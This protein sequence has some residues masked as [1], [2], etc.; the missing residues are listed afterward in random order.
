MNLTVT[1]L[2][3]LLVVNWVLSKENHVPTC[4]LP[5]MPE[6]DL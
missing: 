3:I 2:L 6:G 4:G 1:K 5:V